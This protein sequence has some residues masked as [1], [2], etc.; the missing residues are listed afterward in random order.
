VRE[1]GGTERPGLAIT[2]SVRTIVE[3]IVKSLSRY[4]STSLYIYQGGFRPWIWSL[5]CVTNEGMASETSVTPDSPEALGLPPVVAD[6]A[7]VGRGAALQLNGVATGCVAV[8]DGQL[9]AWTGG[10]L[11]TSHSGAHQRGQDGPP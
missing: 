4:L 9:F 8:D 5:A 10:L 6:P 11:V 1:S 7:N 2:L 3:Q